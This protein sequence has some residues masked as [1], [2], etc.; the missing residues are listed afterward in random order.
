M[1]VLSLS[2]TICAYYL[3]VLYVRIIPLMLY[4]RIIPLLPYMRVIPLLLVRII[5]LMLC[6][7]CLPNTGKEVKSSVSTYCT[8]E[9]ASIPMP[10][11]TYTTSIFCN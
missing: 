11:Y 6:A 3:P 1:C 7:Y 2:Y 10:Y 5:P 8:T 9:H 4:V